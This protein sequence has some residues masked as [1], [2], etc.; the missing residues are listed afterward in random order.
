MKIVIKNTLPENLDPINVEIPPSKF[1]CDL[2]Q[3]QNCSAKLKNVTTTN[4]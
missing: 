3:M 1:N 2:L 4:W